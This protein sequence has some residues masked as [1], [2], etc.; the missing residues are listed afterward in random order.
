MPTTIHIAPDGTRS[1][2]LPN[3]IARNGGTMAIASTTTN[4]EWEAIGGT[5]EIVPDTPALTAEEQAAADQANKTAQA[6]EIAATHPDVPGKVAEVFALVGYA[7]ANLG[8]AF[9]SDRLP[10]FAEI[11]QALLDADT[12]EAYRLYTQGRLNWDIILA[13]CG[14]DYHLAY[15]L[16]PYLAALA[17]T[18]PE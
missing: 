4:A 18:P 8:V 3:T 9:P 11:G 6:A 10:T 14:S 16:A 17:T 7:I 1:K 13:A 12:D 15:A 2:G 5:I